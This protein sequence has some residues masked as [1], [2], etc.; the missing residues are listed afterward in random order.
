MLNTST[1]LC[2][3]VSAS[4]CLI[5]IP[6]QLFTQL[7]LHAY[8]N[9]VIKQDEVINNKENAKLRMRL[10]YAQLKLDMYRA[11]HKE[12]L[13]ELDLMNKKYESASTKLKNQLAS[14]GIEV[15][16]LKKQLAAVKEH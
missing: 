13:D 2:I 7:D 9:V 6:C 1:F 8:F 12:A 5:L 15:L 14:Y 10:R 16:N 4:A 11:R 3:F